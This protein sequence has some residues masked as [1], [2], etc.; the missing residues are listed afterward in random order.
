MKNRTI[1]F[2]L[3]FLCLF[4][5]VNSSLS[6][7]E[8]E[9]EVIEEPPI[10]VEG[11]NQQEESNRSNEEISR[12]NLVEESESELD[13]DIFM[14]LLYGVGGLYQSNTF[15]LG[16]TVDFIAT[17][18]GPNKPD[19]SIGFGWAVTILDQDLQYGAPIWLGNYMWDSYLD[20]ISSPLPDGSSSED[21][22]DRLGITL[23][24]WLLA[25]VPYVLPNYLKIGYRFHPN[26]DLEIDIHPFDIVFDRI[27]NKEYFCNSIGIN[28]KMVFETLVIS[29]FVDLRI[30]YET[31][32]FGV[33][34]GIRV[35]FQRNPSLKTEPIFKTE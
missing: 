11:P 18:H 12:P 20:H 1:V 13:R 7:Q 34:P 33:L 6:A 30:I 2:G 24:G 25:S 21:L 15:E 16:H 29:P 9:T 35:G 28:A 22:G 32:N 17:F 27:T 23:I 19:L 26:F 3:I 8:V 31:G 4:L 10:P 14:S 5:Q